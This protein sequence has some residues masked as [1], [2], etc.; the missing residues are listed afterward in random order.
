MVCSGWC[1]EVGG[2]GTYTAND[3]MEM[4]GRC[5]AWVDQRVEPLDGQLGASEPEEAMSRRGEAEGGHHPGTAMHLG[6]GVCE[7][8][9]VNEAESPVCGLGTIRRS[10]STRGGGL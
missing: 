9:I 5:H 2:T 10:E 1:G 4:A 3:L 6:A 7:R 8:M